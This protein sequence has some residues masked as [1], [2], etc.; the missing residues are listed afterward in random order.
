M[1]K[2]SNVTIGGLLLT[3]VIIFSFQGDIILNNP[4]HILLIAIPLTIQTFLIFFIAYLASKALKLYHCIAAPAGMIGASNFFELV[5]RS[6]HFPVRTEVPGCTGDHRRCPDRSSGHADPGQDCQPNQP[7]VPQN[8]G[9]ERMSTDKS[10]KRIVIIGAVA[11]GT[12]AAA[13][14][15]RNDEAAEIVIYEKDQ[16]ISYSG[17]G[18][19]YYI[20]G[21]VEKL[22]ELT[23]RDPEFFRSKYNVDV[24]IRHQVM[25]IDPQAK[26]LVVRNLADGTEFID[27]YDALILSTGATSIVP[28][29]PGVELP[30][31]FTLRNPLSA[32][33]IREAIEQG[34]PKTAVVVGSGFIGLEMVENLVHAGLNV[35]VV[36]KLP[37][38]CPFIDPDL[39]PYLEDCLVKNGVAVRTSVAAAEIRPSKVVLDDG[40]TIDAD[41]VI[42]AVGVRPNTSLAQSIGVELGQTR[43]IAVNSKMQTSIPDVYACGDC[44]ESFSVIDGQPLY[45]PLGS[46]ANKMGRIAGDVVTGGSLE[47]R[48][49]AGT[50]IFKVFDMAIAASGLNEKQARDSGYDIV[51]SHNIK[52]DKPEYYGGK[53]MVIKAIADRKSEKLLGVQIIGY[54]GVDKRI[55]VFVT[56]MTAGMTVDDLFHLDLAYAPPFSTTKD[57]VMY[58][59]MILDNALHRGRELITADVLMAT[60]PESIQV[61][62]ARVAKQY[63]EHH[64]DHAVNMPHSSLREQMTGLDKE[65]PVVTYC[66]K[67]TTG[68]AVQNILLNHG[69]KKVYNLSGGHKQYKAC[70]KNCKQQK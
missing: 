33:A 43:A 37:Q 7:M 55:D 29:I 63:Q 56:A 27:R 48:G 60:D 2:F 67:G 49:I 62:D 4:L 35:T 58:T 16:H 53:E 15:R 3:L 42:M 9:I 51:I 28:Q 11:A 32:K 26:K 22:E 69:F 46:T 39:A 6:R 21:K 70:K 5:R 36:E 14:A 17:C 30:H 18:L 45:R 34:Q 13:K 38:I 65:K 50:G 68:N 47:F 66:N 54:E 24:L 52:P 59:G 23:P 61:V 8:G 31:V 41:L 20:G 1:P 19:P 12:S 57:P 64:V 10:A 25:S 44:T 40:T